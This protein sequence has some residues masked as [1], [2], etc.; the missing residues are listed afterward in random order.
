MSEISHLEERLT[1]IEA[2]LPEICKTTEIQTSILEDLAESQRKL[3]NVLAGIIKALKNGD[4]D[5]E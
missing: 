3:A 2:L 1:D 5:N 4:N